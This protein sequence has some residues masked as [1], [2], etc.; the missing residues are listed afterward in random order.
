MFQLNFGTISCALSA[1]DSFVDGYRWVDINGGET[2]RGV[3]LR[4]G[5][6]YVAVGRRTYVDRNRG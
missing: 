4:I 3:G 2:I 6:L 5:R 1:Y